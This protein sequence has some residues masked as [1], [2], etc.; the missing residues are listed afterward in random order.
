MLPWIYQKV[1][2]LQG[3]KWKCLLNAYKGY[4]QVL[5]KKEDE[6]K[7]TFYTDNGKFV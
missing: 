2:S 6:E 1:E 3:F 7:T 4:H 5:M